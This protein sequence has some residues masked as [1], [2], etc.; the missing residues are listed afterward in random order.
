M[1]AFMPA[2]ANCSGA[3]PR[4]DRDFEQRCPGARYLAGVGPGC[5]VDR[6]EEEVGKANV[7]VGDEGWIRE[8]ECLQP[9]LDTLGDIE[10]QPGEASNTV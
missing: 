5:V 3:I 2:I 10:V 6:G 4:R 1:W 7:E 8:P 9:R